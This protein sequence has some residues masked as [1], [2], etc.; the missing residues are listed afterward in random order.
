MLSNPLL[1]IFSPTKAPAMITPTYTDVFDF[2][3][4]ERERKKRVNKWMMM[5]MMK[6]RE[7]GKEKHHHHHIIIK[8]VVYRVKQRQ[9]KEKRKKEVRSLCPPRNKTASARL[10]LTMNVL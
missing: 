4:E 10:K 1:T 9:T 5:M 6:M 7:I 2:I 3:F 8:S